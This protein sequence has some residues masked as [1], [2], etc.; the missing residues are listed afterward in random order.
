MGQVGSR[1]KSL[2][3]PWEEAVNMRNN[4]GCRSGCVEVRGNTIEEYKRLELDKINRSIN[5]DK[6]QGE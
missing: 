1:L 5:Y 2:R 6:F 4:H 3:N